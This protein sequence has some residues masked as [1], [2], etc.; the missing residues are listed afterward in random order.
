M[1]EVVVVAMAS[2][3]F[4]TASWVCWLKAEKGVRFWV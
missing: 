1:R 3:G 2:G 4:A